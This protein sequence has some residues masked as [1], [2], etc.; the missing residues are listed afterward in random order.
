MDGENMLSR[1]SDSTVRTLLRVGKKNPGLRAFLSHPRGMIALR[2][3]AARRGIY[4]TECEAAEVER[5]VYRRMYPQ[6]R[7]K[8]AGGWK[9]R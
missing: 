8:D 2:N 7:D 6:G 5:D 1:L 9:R 3:E 4:R